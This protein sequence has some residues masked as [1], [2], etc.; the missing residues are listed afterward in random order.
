VN[1]SRRRTPN[2]QALFDQEDVQAL[3]EAVRFQD[4]RRDHQGHA[5]DRGSPV[6]R[7]AVLALGRLGVEAG[8]GAVAAALEDPVDS[9]RT[10]AVEVLSERGE[11][12]EL[13]KALH[14][15]PGGRGTSRRL[16][17]QAVLEQRTPESAGI[18]AAALVRAPGEGPLSDADN[19]FIHA[20][21]EPAGRRK[22]VNGVV[23]E[24]LSAL[25]DERE[26]VADRA[27]ELLVKL[28]PASTRAVVRELRTGAS[29][30]R[31][32]AVLSGIGDSTAVL[33][34]IEGLERDNVDLR[35]Q[36]AAA[37]GWL[38]H[39][40]AVEPLL[41]ATRD[42]HPDVRAEATQALDRMGTAAVIVGTS[43]QLRPVIA[44]AVRTASATPT[45]PESNSA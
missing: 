3:S 26:A 41:R 34:L 21:A 33:G 38:R 12:T 42:Q 39:L 15:L 6:R 30:E 36:A 5:D 16:A 45:P 40:D 11:V 24:L 43:A 29:P 8:N 31:A 7:E 14:W 9:V 22:P 13:S 2:I 23:R 18:A 27:E 35:I 44:A 10:A 32:I 17:A 1:F 37:L 20:L 4:R 25:A 19:D 28:A